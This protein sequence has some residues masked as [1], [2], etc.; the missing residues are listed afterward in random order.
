MARVIT[1]EMAL[2][3]DPEKVRTWEYKALSTKISPKKVAK[4]AR[5][6]FLVVEK[7]IGVTQMSVKVDDKG[8]HFILSENS[9]FTQADC[10][11]AVGL[12]SSAMFQ[13]MSERGVIDNVK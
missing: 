1:F 7:G 13:I 3:K 12:I 11:R 10:Q 8:T 4:G 2:D 6:T 5:P 9:E